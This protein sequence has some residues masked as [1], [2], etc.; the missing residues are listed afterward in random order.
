RMFRHRRRVRS[1]LVDRVPARGACR[2]S[3]DRSPSHGRRNPRVGA[4]S[5]RIRRRA[6]GDHPA[7]S[8]VMRRSADGFSVIELTVALA[9]TLIV[10][11]TVAAIVGPAR[12]VFD[13]QPEAIDVQQRLRV[14]VEALT[15]DLIGAGAGS[16][17]GGRSG[18]LAEVVPPVLPFRRGAGRSDPPD[19]FR[20]DA[21]TIIS[22][23][24]TAV[25]TTLAADFD[26]GAT[27]LTVMPTVGCGEGVTLCGVVPGMTVL[28]SEIGGAFDLFDVTA[29]DDAASQLTVTPASGASAYPTG[30]P[31]VEARVRTYYLKNDSVTHTAQLMRSD[32]AATGDAPVLDHVA[33]LTFDYLSAS[34]TPIAASEL[35]DGPWLP[36]AA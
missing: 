11:G 34:G 14:G 1:S 20:S 12:S 16:P 30:V 8:D 15:R 10:A 25:Q 6:P 9:L 13:S 5:A 19:T 17:V 21:I 32:S 33:A 35:A 7:E 27:A 24:A 26:V 23:P 29:V 18:P 31:V 3:G 2:G 22:V 4:C 36:N 28:V